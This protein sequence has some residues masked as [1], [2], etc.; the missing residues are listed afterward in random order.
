MAHDYVTQAE[1]LVTRKW[2][3]SGFRS[4]RGRLTQTHYREAVYGDLMGDLARS[5]AWQGVSLILEYREVCA[6]PSACDA[7]WLDVS[8]PEMHGSQG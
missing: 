3:M 8:L 7:A 5:G 6:S 1:G 4:R 2:G